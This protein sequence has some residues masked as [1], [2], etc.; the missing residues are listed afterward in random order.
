MKVEREA[1]DSVYVP[2]TQLSGDALSW[3]V[4]Y[5]VTG[6]KH[7]LVAGWTGAAQILWPLYHSSWA[8]TGPLVDVLNIEI[9]ELPKIYPNPNP[10]FHALMLGGW[11]EEGSSR[12]E[13]VCRTIVTSKFGRLVELPKIFV[14]RA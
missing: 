3:L 6:R 10:R 1:S 5:A 13:A 4:S 14:N 8:A 7:P 11:A 2:I 9:R 12:L